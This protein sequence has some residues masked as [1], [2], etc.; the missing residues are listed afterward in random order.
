MCGRYAIFDVS[1]IYERFGVNEPIEGLTQRYNAA[2][3]Q[4]LP[5]IFEDGVRKIAL[6]RWGLIPKWAK[7]AKIGNTMINARLETLSQKPSYKKPLEKQRCLVP[8]NGFYEWH[9]QNRKQPYYFN[10]ESGKLL[11]FAGLYDR[12]TDADGVEVD[13]Y[14]IVTTEAQGIVAKV[15]ERMPLVL[16]EEDEEKWLKVTDYPSDKILNL[17]KPDAASLIGY[18][19]KRAVNRTEQDSPSLLEAI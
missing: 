3:S 2:P 14:T 15:H 17:V 5:V 4:T 10:R 13:S 11:A 19:V 18:P 12:W 7:D 6:M 1:Q 8:A 16:K 9:E